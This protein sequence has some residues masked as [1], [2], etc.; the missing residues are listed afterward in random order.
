MPRLN[1]SEAVKER[2][3]HLLAR[4]LAY[5]NHELP[6]D[7][8]R[9]QKKLT[10]RW[11]EAESDR[12]KLIVK[13]ELRFLAELV[14]QRQS[15]KLKETLKQDLQV[16]SKFLDILEDNRTKTQGSA[17]WHFTLTLWHKS[18][19]KNRREFQKQ[20]DRQKAKSKPSDNYSATPKPEKGSFVRGTSLLPEPV[21]GNGSMANEVPS[22]PDSSQNRP[23]SIVYRN[24]PA[25][26]HVDFMGRQT[27]LNQLL[28]WLNLDNA[29]ARISVEGIG[30]VGKTSL[31]LEAAYRCLRTKGTTSEPL[32]TPSF[33][34]IIFTSAKRKH[35]TPS[36]VLKRFKREHTLGHILAA[37]AR[38]LDRP[39]LLA[40][41]LDDQ[42]ENVLSS[43]GRQ[44]TLLIVDNLETL[45]EQ[46]DLLSFLYDL[47]STVKTIV[48][49]RDR[50]PLDVSIQL[51]P[52]AAADRLPFVQ[53][54]AQL[55]AVQLNPDEAQALAQGT[56]GIP[57]AMVYAMGQLANGYLVQDVLP[58]LTLANG[59]FCRF[60]LEGSVKPLR[61]QT[62]HKLLMALALFPQPPLRAA[63]AQVALPDA[64]MTEGFA[65]LH[66]LSLV[67]RQGGRF[68]LLPLTRDY[69]S[70]ELSTNAEFEQEARERW[71]HWYLCFL[72]QQSNDDWQEWNDW[73][74]L[75]EERE[76]LTAVVEWCIDQNRYDDFKT[77]WQQLK[78]WTHFAGYWNERLD[79]MDWFIQ[80]AQA[81]QDWATAAAA[82]FDQGQTL[83]LIDRSEQRRAAIALF[84]QAWTLCD[85]EDAALRFAIAAN[86][87]GLYLKQEQIEAAQRWLQQAEALLAQL[88]SP[89]GA[90]SREQTTILYY[91]A[92]FY[93]NAGEYDRA[94]TL[95]ETALVQ[96]EAMDWQRATTYLRNWIAHIALVTGQLDE[97][98]R[99]LQINLPIA[100]H[101]ND[102]RCTAFCQK[103]LARIEQARGNANAARCY[104]Q[105]A[106]EGFVQLSMNQE[107]AELDDLIDP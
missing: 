17:V 52:L 90:Y 62:A 18:A 75:E 65:R 29:A 86:N 19:D 83:A 60:Y 20:W 96:A 64:D 34:A 43:L 54:Q 13:T 32:A 81:R 23:N 37:V 22:Q 8:E 71:L 47:P 82:M 9:L 89:E 4:L 11:L 67:T 93:F 87:V 80:A 14:F 100:Q 72:Q 1:T 101:Y 45:E 78:G 91:Q 99:L 6:E 24:L 66:Q 88:P 5:A 95:Y 70:A 7:W 77:L 69:A 48:T 63:V 105:V 68:D 92:Q 35:F 56:G 76:N 58:R 106:R 31:V 73:Q 39:A 27:Q 36:G 55:K 21:L 61:G 85:A 40:G 46:D 3:E 16:L 59:E 84:E 41:E 74:A 102:R 42:I 26:T 57:A 33:D 25:C 94:R 10:V 53:H 50:I 97:A 28:D 38:T 98:E 107:V 15:P 12:P 104:A 79:W 103:F 2:I 51:D 30:G 44:Q 49:S